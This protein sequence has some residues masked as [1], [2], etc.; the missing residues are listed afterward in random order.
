MD[1]EADKSVSEWM[2]APGYE[3]LQKGELKKWLGV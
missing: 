1:L 3:R 2:T